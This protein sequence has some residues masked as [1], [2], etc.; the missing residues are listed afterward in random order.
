MT[1]PSPSPFSAEQL[2]ELE[3]AKLRAKK[4][5]R[6]ANIASIDGG[7]TAFFAFFAMLSFCMGIDAVLLGL[8]LAWVAFSSFRGAA[9]LKK[10]DPAAPA[11]LACNQGVL[12]AAITVYA[13]YNWCRAGSLAA[14]LGQVIGDPS[15]L[16]GLP[17]LAVFTEQ[18]QQ[19]VQWVPPLLY[20]GLILGSFFAQGL[21][22][23]YYFTRRSVLRAYLESTPGWVLD[24]QCRGLV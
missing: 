3:K 23:L 14:M 17:E 13:I 18:V 4:V 22:A 5:R 7:I 10:L 11:L 16:A 2:L 21:T 1:V 24:L 19:I 12:F 9:R 8:V 6:A 20:G 15:L